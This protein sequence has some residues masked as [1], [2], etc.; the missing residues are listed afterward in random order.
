[1]IE[2]I[3]ARR[4]RAAASGAQGRQELREVAQLQRG[5]G[6]V[7]AVARQPPEHALPPEARRGERVEELEREREGDLGGGLQ[8]PG[9]SGWVPAVALG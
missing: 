9:E 5:H 2:Y 1:M 3:P 4:R 7:V 8:R 6:V